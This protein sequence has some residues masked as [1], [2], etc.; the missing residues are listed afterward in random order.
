MKRGLDEEGVMGVMGVMAGSGRG[1]GLLAGRGG[2]VK[3]ALTRCYPHALSPPAFTS[4]DAASRQRLAPR[5][6][7]RLMNTSPKIS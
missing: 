7:L 3:V 4:L 5:A 2:A 1:G 6:R